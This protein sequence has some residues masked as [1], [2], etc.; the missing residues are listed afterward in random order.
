MSDSARYH[1][2]LWA[3]NK[4][5]DEIRDEIVRV[6]ALRRHEGVEF[7][8]ARVRH[9]RAVQLEELNRLLTEGVTR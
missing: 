7:D 5:P 1:T 9:R 4:T 8:D 6:Q 3:T 2:R